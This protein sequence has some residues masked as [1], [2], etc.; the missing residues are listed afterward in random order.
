MS[1]FFE[2]P[3]PH[4][5]INRN[6]TIHMA[7]CEGN[8]CP[9]S[10]CGKQF[11]KKENLARHQRAVHEGVKHPCPRCDYQAT[12]KR[13]LAVHLRGVH[14]GVKYPCRQCGKQFSQKGNLA[15]LELFQL[16]LDIQNYPVF[17]ILYRIQDE[18]ILYPKVFCLILNK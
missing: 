11:P 18:T 9:C 13:G 14:E 16:I 6:E 10:Q 1:V 7:S 17:S 5:Q 8:K 12:T 15:E 3:F 4:Q 2:L